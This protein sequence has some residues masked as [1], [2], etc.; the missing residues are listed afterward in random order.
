MDALG[1]VAG[2][3]AVDARCV[4]TG[5]SALGGWQVGTPSMHVTSPSMQ[6]G[7]TPTLPQQAS[8]MAA[9][10]LPPSM[11]P[12]SLHEV[13]MLDGGGGHGGGNMLDG[14]GGGH[15]GVNMLDCTGG[16]H[17]GVNMLDGAGGH[18]GTSVPDLS[19]APAEACTG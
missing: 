5:V 17:G 6:Q 10:G 13:N 15:D 11:H 9:A 19:H 2:G 8:G 12:S 18:A 1:E 14:A 7:D 3:H 16:G 4:V